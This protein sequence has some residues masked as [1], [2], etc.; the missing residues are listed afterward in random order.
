MEVDS[1][2]GASQAS[3]DSDFGAQAASRT[4]RLLRVPFELGKRARGSWREGIGVTRDGKSWEVKKQVE[5]DRKEGSVAYAES[6]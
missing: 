2:D 5:G 3:D 4:G 6:A 1:D